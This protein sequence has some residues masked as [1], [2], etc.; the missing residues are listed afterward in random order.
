MQ[1][2]FSQQSVRNQISKTKK[3]KKKKK[4]KKEGK[5]DRCVAGDSSSKKDEDVYRRY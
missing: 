4:K 3:K 2:C 1:R 5:R